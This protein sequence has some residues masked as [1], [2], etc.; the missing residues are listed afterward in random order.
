MSASARSLPKSPAEQSEERTSET[1]SGT[2]DALLRAELQEKD[3]TISELQ[4]MLRQAQEANR[5]TQQQVA[6][7]QTRLRDAETLAGTREEDLRSQNIRVR[8]LEARGIDLERAMARLQAAEAARVAELTDTAANLSAQSTRVFELEGQLKQ[9][10]GVLASG[11][12]WKGRAERLQRTVDELR[13]AAEVLCRLS[14][15]GC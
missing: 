1:G 8:E 2:S 10:Q 7:L 3:G 4:S 5:R 14:C 12:E 6:E 9:L 13:A 11:G 15:L